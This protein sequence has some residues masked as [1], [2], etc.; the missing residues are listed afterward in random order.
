M[1]LPSANFENGQCKKN[2]KSGKRKNLVCLVWQLIK[3]SRQCV[4]VCVFALFFFFLFAISFKVFCFC[5]AASLNIIAGLCLRL[6]AI[7]WQTV[8]TNTQLGNSVNIDRA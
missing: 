8:H 1:L 5:P 2:K 4:C 6:E 3:A 7:N